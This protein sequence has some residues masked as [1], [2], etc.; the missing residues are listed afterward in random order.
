MG[1]VL[2]GE[3]RGVLD[4][5]K[6]SDGDEMRPNGLSPLRSA[7]KRAVTNMLG[8]FSGALNIQTMLHLRARFDVDA[9][10][11]DFEIGSR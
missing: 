7:S 10:A 1:A 8:L 11:G 5:H 4:V 9:C 6:A 2:D 3:R